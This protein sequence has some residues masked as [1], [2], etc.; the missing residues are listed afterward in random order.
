[1]ELMKSIC[2]GMNQILIRYICQYTHRVN[3][4]DGM[5]LYRM[6]KV[7]ERSFKVHLGYL[8]SVHHMT[9]QARARNLLFN[10]AIRGS[11]QLAAVL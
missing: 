8:L 10:H 4:I 11:S 6:I 9:T 1:M 5:C 3:M 7:P 2:Q